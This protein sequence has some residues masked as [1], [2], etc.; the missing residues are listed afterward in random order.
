[1]TEVKKHVFPPTAF[2]GSREEGKIGY[3]CR[4]E[5]IWF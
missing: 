2:V 3:H 4:I 5:E 1:M